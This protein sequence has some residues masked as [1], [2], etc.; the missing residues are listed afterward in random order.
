MKTLTDICLMV[1][2][3]PP[4][5]VRKASLSPGFGLELIETVLL[6]H[7][8]LFHSHGELNYLLSQRI[9][10]LINRVLAE[11]QGYSLTVRTTRIFC[12]LLREYLP[13]IKSEAE[14]ALGLFNQILDSENS[15]PWRRALCMETF[16]VLYSSSDLVIRVYSL[17]DNDEKKR[18]IIQTNLATFVRLASEKP[19]LIGVG[20][21]SSVPSTQVVSKASSQEQA[22]IDAGN[23]AGMIGGD[24][25][26]SE[27]NAPGISE[28]WSTLKVPCLDQLDKP[29][30]PYIP[31]TYVYSLVL[32]CMTNL[33]D[34]LA[35]L[36]LPVSMQ[37]QSKS[38]RKSRAATLSGQQKPG[39]T[40]ERSS[41]NE[42]DRVES[43]RRRERS[44]PVNPLDLK[45]H[46]THK[47]IQTIVDLLNACWPAILATSSTFVYAALDA[48]FYRGLV[49]S[50]QKFTQISGLLRLSTPRDAFLTTLAKAAVPSNLFKTDSV[51]SPGTATPTTEY[52]ESARGLVRQNSS[53]SM[54]SQPSFDSPSRTRRPS[55]D[56]NGPTLTQRNLM[57]LRALVNLAIALGPILDS[58][59]HIVLD[60]LQKAS[61]LIA[62]SAT[63][64]SARDFRSTQSN[65]QQATQPSLAS[66][67]AAVEG[68]VTRMFQSTSDYSNESFN[69]ML[70]ALCSLLRSDKPQ[71]KPVLLQTPLK[72]PRRVSSTSGLPSSV[73]SQPQLSHFAIAK[74]GELAHVNLKRLTYD[75]EN[76]G[77][78]MFMKSATEV[79][80]SG[81]EDASGRLMAVEVV[82]NTAAEAAILSSSEDEDVSPWSS[83]TIACSTAGSSDQLKG[84]RQREGTTYV[85]DIDVHVAVLES[86]HS[87]LERC[88]ESLITGWPAVFEILN[89]AFAKDQTR[90]D[91]ENSNEGND[92][93]LESLFEPVSGKLLR[94]SF[95][96]IQLICSDFLDALPKA[97]NISLV[98]LLS[99]FCAQ[100]IDMNMSLT[101]SKRLVQE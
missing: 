63:A 86:L 101:V 48:D 33:S 84:T 80:A 52:K 40:E 13:D 29:E 93:R 57:C 95:A 66:E 18:G 39:E 100:K 87:I 99:A 81:E 19:N 56:L 26:V 73:A 60:N 51:Y 9:M 47:S 90:P 43:L 78:N 74:I 58:G 61:V 96:S 24:F 89:S 10:P 25:G 22:V 3:E 16:R 98:D 59:W 11:R 55:L 65:D 1:E 62:V 72:G 75:A 36:I 15:S 83:T 4:Q 7:E 67:I 53:E 42:V 12:I 31:E 46:P 5:F 94:P 70:S 97:S 92:A 64:A 69:T 35:K 41:K 20:Q 82:A 14:V 27:V 77:W 79:C 23:A 28:Q 8:D 71:D 32:A 49:R 2:A 45:D 85:G 6:G 34:V 50:I 21:Q 91:V 44:I 88:G 76:G 54:H 30:P 17:L 37:N 38:S 68:A